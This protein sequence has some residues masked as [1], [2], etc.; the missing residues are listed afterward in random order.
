MVNYKAIA[1]KAE[2]YSDYETAYAA[3]SAETKDEYKELSSNNLREW[4]VSNEDDYNLIKTSNLLICEMSMKQI[5]IDSSPLDMRKESIR[6]LVSLL[7]ISAP[8]KVSLLQAATIQVKVWPNLK[9]GH[10]QNALQKRAEGKV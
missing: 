6:G 8:G 3:M 9:P 2:Q 7:P 5:E 10:I 1:D 4:A